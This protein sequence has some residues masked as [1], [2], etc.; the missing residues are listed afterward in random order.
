MN[1]WWK[2]RNNGQKQNQIQ[3]AIKN[4]EQKVINFYFIG[5]IKVS[6]IYNLLDKNTKNLS[7]KTLNIT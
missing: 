1:N 5:I 3:L 6:N 2:S 4:D 7:H